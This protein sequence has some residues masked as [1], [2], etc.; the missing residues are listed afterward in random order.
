MKKL[1]IIIILLMNSYSYAQDVSDILIPSAQ[2]ALSYI[3]AN[4]DLKETAK[5][6]SQFRAKEYIMEYII[7]SANNKAI[8]F[9]TESLASDNSAGLISIAFNCDEVDERGL[10]LAFVGNN[11]DENGNVGIA[12]GFKYIPLESAQK[13]LRTI[14]LVRA[15][16]D[17]YLAAEENV[18]NVY[19]ESDD[20]KF[21]LYKD[22]GDQLRVFWNGFEVIWEKVAF[23]RTKRRLD[24]WFK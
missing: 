3:A 8:K 2:A 15:N 10:L 7:G 9:E 21:I 23:D 24:K 14:N 12:Y 13:L 16:N 17:K 11:R 5:E 19:I 22:G 6:V 1:I 18:N 20:I 4:A